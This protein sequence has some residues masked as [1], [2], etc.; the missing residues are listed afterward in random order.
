MKESTEWEKEIEWLKKNRSVY[1][2]R[3]QWGL[4][5]KQ[6]KRGK[7]VEYGNKEKT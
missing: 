2:K 1:K 3:G 6:R 4:H 5:W 7:E